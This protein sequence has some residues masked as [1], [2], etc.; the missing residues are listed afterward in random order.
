MNQVASGNLSLIFC[1][2]TVLVYHKE[3]AWGM[4]KTGGKQEVSQSW[5]LLLPMV[6]WDIV[7]WGWEQ[8]PIPLCLCLSGRRSDGWL[9]YVGVLGNH[10]EP[11]LCC[12]WGSLYKSSVALMKPPATVWAQWGC[13]SQG[14]LTDKIIFSFVENRCFHTIHSYYGFPSVYSFQFFPTCPLIQ[15]HPL[16]VSC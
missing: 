16:P 13:R 11:E 6:G 7:E 8:S 12:R 14:S 2:T 5:G 9:C 15:I 10:L 4:V 3:S 1:V